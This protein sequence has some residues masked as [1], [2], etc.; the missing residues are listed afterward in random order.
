MRISIYH[1]FL[2]KKFSLALGVTLLTITLGVQTPLL[3]KVVSIN[4]SNQV[5]PIENLI[6]TSICNSANGAHTWRVRNPNDVDVSISYE[7]VGTGETGLLTAKGNSDTFF[8]ATNKGTTKIFWKNE[9]DEDK[10]TVKA[11]NN[12]DCKVVEKLILTSICNSPGGAHTWRVRNPNSF[13]VEV[14]YLVVGN[15]ETGTVTAKANSDT[16][17]DA[18]NKG[19][20]KI[21][22][23]DGTF[24]QQETVK[25]PNNNDCKV[26]EKLILTSI[27]NSPGGAHTWRV[28][29][30]NSF[31]VEVD[32]LVV[33]NGETGTITAKANSDTFFDAAN[34]GTTKIFWLDGTFK[35]QETVKA[36]NNNDCKV[37]EKLILTSICNSPG[38]AHT[39]RVR[40]P[41]NF[42]V[43]V[44]YLVVGNG[45]TGTITA[46]ANSDTFFDAANKGTTKIF[47][48]DGTFKQQETVKAPNNN[49]CKVVE[50]LILTSICNSESGSHTWRVRNPNSFDVEVDYLV[51]GNGE[52]GT[53]TAKANSDTFF[54]AANKGTTK[55]FW[56]DGTFKQQETVKAPNNNDCKVVEK[57]ILTS[58][59][60]SE[61]GSHTWRV[62]NPNN[63]DVEVDYLVVGNGE[64]GT[65]TAKANSDTFFDAA[66]KGTTKI[67]W[68]DGT[69]KQQE[70]VKAPNNNDCKVVEKLILTSICNSPGGAHTWRVRNPNSFD[71]EVDYLVVGNGETGT[72]TAKA[73]SD[74]FFDAANKGTTKIFWL[75][76]TFK[77]Q[78]TVKAPNNNDC[79]VVEKLILTSICNSPG[80]A[81]TW[82]VRNPNNFDV[83]VDYLVVGNG[84]TGTI[85]AKANSDTFFD[86]AN[87]G[88]TK[89][90]WL[91]GT[92]KQQE[93]VKAPNNNDCKV[94]EKL[95]LTSICNSE[96]GSH[97]WRVRNPNSFDV[98]VDYLVVGNGETGTV[99]AKANSDTFF[100][101]A[102]K[103][104]TKIFWLDGTFKQQ[105]TVKAPNN[106]PCIIVEKL[107]LTSIC[108]KSD[109]SHTWRV[110]NPN[111]FDVEVDY[112]VVG[113]GETGT[114]TA[115]A[116]DD[117]FF[118]AANKGTTKIFWLDQKNNQQETVKAPNNEICDEC[119][120]VVR[121][122]LWDPKTNTKIQDLKDGN[123][124]NIYD[125]GG[126]LTVIAFIDGQ[127]ER[128][129]FDLSGPV[130]YNRTERKAPYA[131]FGDTDGKLG[132][133]L[134]LPVGKYE[135]CVTPYESRTEPCDKYCIEF[136]L[137][138]QKEVKNLIL[139][140]ICNNK[141]GSHNWRVRNPNSFDINVDY[142]VVGNGET[143]SLIAKANDDTFFDAANK[144]TTKIFWQDESGSQK[145]TVKAPNN[146][147]CPED[148][149]PD[150]TRLELWDPKTNTKLQDIMDGD[151]INIANIGGELTVIAI[152]DGQ[153]ERVVFALSGE[154][155]YNRTERKAPYA[156]FGDTNGKLGIQLDLKPGD[157]QLCVRPYKS[158]TEA[159]DEVCI[160]FELT[161]QKVVEN[162]KL[163]S[164]CNQ[165]N[166]AHKWRVRNPNPY[167]VEVSYQVVGT[168]EN[169]NLI[170]KANDDTFFYATNKG[171][172]KIFWQDENDAQQETVKA[173]NNEMCPDD[174]CPVVEKFELYDAKQD[175]M[176]GELKEGDLLNTDQLGMDLTVVAIVNGTASKVKMELGGDASYS[177]TEKSLPYALFGDDNGDYSTSTL[178]TPG[179]YQVM[180]TPYNE[181]GKACLTSVVNFTVIGQ[182]AF[183]SFTSLNDLDEDPLQ[184]LSTFPNPANEYLTIQATGFE[185][186]MTVR[187]ADV[188]GRII[189]HNKISFSQ[190]HTLNLDRISSGIYLMI[191][192]ANDQ[193]VIKRIQ[194]NR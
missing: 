2:K 111:A 120:Q 62:R 73:N 92:F 30:P 157:Y 159:C 184:N 48:L 193:Q 77:Q 43:E 103:G 38:G 121:L 129:V 163:T 114:L 154:T 44:D 49:D 26:V 170:A 22:W 72:V 152:V 137:F 41:N 175:V 84:E 45:E 188:N 122:E 74:T 171:T 140:S 8:D 167:D 4:E 71:V 135:L 29:N 52:T 161:K 42:D 7:V 47:W 177:R 83:E 78:E 65:V 156:L 130:S 132:I 108:N 144:G 176:I 11:P 131:L 16:F 86:A 18:A 80:G 142:L 162:L 136:E 35:Q 27:C 160:N 113:N 145:E 10:E 64:T 61:S 90:F 69:F 107:I 9:L 143:G 76:G 15:G 46:K 87:K 94:V 194:I 21:F 168:A 178:F 23:L 12:N 134:D 117:T 79:K 66:N 82:R 153:P 60:N 182:S 128:V 149:C 13:D 51:V 34:K 173:P 98:E 63:F 124:V 17:F 53:V 172:T 75:D 192:N 3:G 101:A 93:T 190:S 37:V 81:H 151:K 105:E 5:A 150:V 1:H 179:S 106:E 56:L 70:T 155:S 187:I 55:I 138:K 118:D 100:D 126:E 123:K 141:D 40:N 148:D 158:R 115:K 166:G 110:R 68:L 191:I 164:I 146:V 88:T 20:T 39:W 147:M 186:P 6:L 104:T 36:P 54:D 139:T 58:I 33:G 97:T 102:N 112:L 180:A 28:R 25:A 183:S 99:T 24:K 14:D 127:P 116:N 89:I 32:Y 133:Q 189:E 169:G 109:G 96:S 31:D 95:I 125:L 59:C 165:K 67:F 174:G 91:D 119:P 50:K 181:D 185:G 85:T 57:L 19:T